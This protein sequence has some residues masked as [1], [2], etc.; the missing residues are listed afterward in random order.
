MGWGLRIYGMGA[1][2]AWSGEQWY[3]GV[4]IIAKEV[5]NVFNIVYLV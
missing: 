5:L 1:E 4:S 3:T 2:G